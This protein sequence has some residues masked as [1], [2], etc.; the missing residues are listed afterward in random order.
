[1]QVP[2]ERNSLSEIAAPI[3]KTRLSKFIIQQADYIIVTLFNPQRYNKL[4]AIMSSNVHAK[5]SNLAMLFM[6]I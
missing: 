2:K 5:Q 6:G 1:M 4:T 3:C